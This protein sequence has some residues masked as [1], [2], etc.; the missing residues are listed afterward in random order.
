MAKANDSPVIS[1]RAVP[2]DGGRA[3]EV[4]MKTPDKILP[5]GRTY[6]RV[7]LV[8]SRIYVLMLVG[9]EGGRLVRERDKFFDSF[10]LLQ[11]R[12][13]VYTDGV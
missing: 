13:A 2:F 4:E 12:G 3:A 6:C 5:G 11:K 9:E 8:G 7:Y 1:K 10:K